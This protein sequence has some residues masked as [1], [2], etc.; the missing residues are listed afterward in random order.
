M[1]WTRSD[2]TFRFFYHVGEEFIVGFSQIA[3]FVVAR[4]VQRALRDGVA[5]GEGRDAGCHLPER[6]RRKSQNDV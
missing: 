2:S 6:T 1:I 4:D 3:D 5:R